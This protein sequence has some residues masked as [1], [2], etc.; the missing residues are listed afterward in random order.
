MRSTCSAC[1]NA[2]SVPKPAAKRI[3]P[4]LLPRS[5]VAES[6]AA[7]SARWRSASAVAG[8]AGSEP[9]M[10]ER[11]SA[12]SRTVRAIGPAVSWL[13]LIGTIRLRLTMPTVGLKPTMPLI[14]AGQVIEP[15][16]SVPIAA[17]TMPAATA[18]PLPLDEPQGL[19]LS[20]NG[21]RVWPPT[22]LQ[23]EM[24]LFERMFAH[25]ER[26]VLPTITAPAWRSRATSGASRLVTLRAR[27]RLPAVVGSG[28]ML[29]I[30]SLIRIG[31]PNSA[32]WRPAR[33]SARA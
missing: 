5:D 31:M 28:P 14:A 21:L 15:S 27:A 19:R 30:L 17:G 18:A 26:L 8:S 7:K 24:E 2:K 29:S 3:T 9:A 20:A 13:W 22:A 32:P 11:T 10:A 33:S 1:S 25:S 6:P 16:V 23:P 12:A 4:I